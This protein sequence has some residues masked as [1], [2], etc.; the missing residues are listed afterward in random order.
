MNKTVS[1]MSMKYKN[2]YRLDYVISN[3]FKIVF[4]RISKLL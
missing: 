4:G 2:S 3:H 1:L